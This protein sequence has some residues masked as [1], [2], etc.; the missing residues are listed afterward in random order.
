MD[1]NAISF[2]RIQDMLSPEGD[3]EA[4]RWANHAVQLAVL[5]KYLGMVTRAPEEGFEGVRVGYVP[6]KTEPTPHRVTATSPDFGIACDC[7]AGAHGK[8]CGHA[9]AMLIDVAFALLIE[10]GI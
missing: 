8:P 2:R 9:G 6:S 4:V 10:G 5:G 3:D 7:Q 1:D